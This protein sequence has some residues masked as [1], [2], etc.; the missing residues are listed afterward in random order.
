MRE[1]P[2][3]IVQKQ[4]KENRE[5]WLIINL[6]IKSFD[7]L[8]QFQ[9]STQKTSVRFFTFVFFFKYCVNIQIR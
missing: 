6:L 8:M 2:I 4:T 5:K 7:C 9:L 3:Q 1:K